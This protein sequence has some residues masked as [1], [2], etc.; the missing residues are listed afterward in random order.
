MDNFSSKEKTQYITAISTLF[1][2]IILCFLSFF[3]HNY[4]IENSILM[5]FG[6]TIIFCSGI[7]GIN[8]YIKSK[9]LEAES[10]INNKV[11]KKMKKVDNL[12][13]DEE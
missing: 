6:Q 4:I 7:F 2:G 3:L 5:Y 1:S 8:I 13:K 12:I 9:V 11:E 10:R